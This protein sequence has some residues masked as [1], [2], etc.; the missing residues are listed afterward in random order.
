MCIILHNDTFR[1]R[2]VTLAVKKL[3][4]TSEYLAYTKKIRKL[5]D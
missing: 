3:S 5:A 2:Y 4:Y 1:K